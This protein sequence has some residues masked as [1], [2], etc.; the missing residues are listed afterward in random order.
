MTVGP[1]PL[2][3]HFYCKMKFEIDANNYN[4]LSNISFNF[5]VLKL[6]VEVKVRS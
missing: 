4:T 1:Y 5:R 6:G 3:Y 2:N